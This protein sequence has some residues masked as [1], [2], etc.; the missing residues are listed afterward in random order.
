MTIKGS[1]QMSIPIVKAFFT[2]NFL[3]RQKLAKNLHFGVKMGSKCEILF[4]TT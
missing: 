2:R 1:L 3:S 4:L